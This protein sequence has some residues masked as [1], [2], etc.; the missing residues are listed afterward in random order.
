MACPPDPHGPEPMSRPDTIVGG[1]QILHTRAGRIL[2]R[3]PGDRDPGA[4][5]AVS[6]AVSAAAVSAAA[7]SA[8]VDGTAGTVGVGGVAGRVLQGT[9]Q[10]PEIGDLL[11]PGRRSAE[12]DRPSGSSSAARRRSL[13]SARV[14]GT[15][16]ARTTIPMHNHTIPT[17]AAPRLETPE[18][19]PRQP[20][21]AATVGVAGPRRPVLRRDDTATAA[22]SSAEGLTQLPRKADAAVKARRG[23]RAG[24][25]LRLAT[26]TRPGP[27]ASWSRN[28]RHA[29]RPAWA[30]RNGSGVRVGRSSSRYPTARWCAA[31][32]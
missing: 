6:T 26:T 15:T 8:P 3:A 18:C 21:S 25:V 28:L 10:V 32:W 31:T 2:T 20:P 24:L 1:M 16:T 11:P 4:I 14:S 23:R 22:R 17:R 13:T 27:A 19:E 12:L 29:C 7:V 5:P 9:A 30:S